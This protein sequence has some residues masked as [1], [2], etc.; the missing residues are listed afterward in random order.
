[1]NLLVIGDVHGCYYTLKNL[2]K[3]NWDPEA[4]I[5][6]QIGDLVNK[7]LHSGKCVK[8]WQKLESQF[9]GK[10]IL[11]KGNH[12]Y[13]LQESLRGNL[14]MKIPG[15]INTI[16]NFNKEKIDLLKLSQ[17]LSERPL[18]WENDHIL[19]THA[20]INKKMEDPYDET[21]KTGV[22]H[23]KGAL[24]RLDKVQVKGHSIVEGHKPVFKPS[25]NAWYID[26]GA[27]DKKNLS[28]LRFSD[29]G[30]MLKIIKERVSEKDQK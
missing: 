13:Q 2:V 28:A 22:L 4:E 16:H 27:W 20:G 24:Q 7:G 9:P 3:K 18:K 8:Y 26:T 25:E 29:E 19:I 1:M 10:V 17:W 15:L 30:K 12:E 23:N 14:K 21:S 6:I 11:I 5:L